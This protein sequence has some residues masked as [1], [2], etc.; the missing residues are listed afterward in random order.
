VTRSEGWDRT[1]IALVGGFLAADAGAILL[2]TALGK[3]VFDM[4]RHELDLG[5]LGLAGFVPAALLVLVSGSV[6]DRHER[7]TVAALAALGSAGASLVVALYV[8]GSPTAAGP[9]FFLA[10][11]VGVAHAFGAPSTRALPADIV[12]PERLPWLVARWSI[13]FQ[14]AHIVGP[15]LAGLLFVVDDSAPFVAAT[16][17]FLAATILYFRTP[18]GLGPR[19]KAPTGPG[20]H[21]AFEGLRLLRRTP[22]LLGAISLDLFAVLFG[23]AVA[24]LP[25]IADERLHVGPVAFG[26][27]RAAPGIGASA[28]MLMLAIRPLQRRI[29]PTLLG[30]VATF[31]VATIV[32]GITRSYVVAFVALVVLAGADAVSVFIRMTLV[33]LVTPNSARGRVMAVEN[34]FIGASNELGA[35]ESGVAGQLLGPGPAVALGGV[36][37][38]LIAAT[39][40]RVFPA[41]RRV[42]HFPA[43]QPDDPVA[44]GESG[45]GG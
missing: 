18:A 39:W 30:A 20:L 45:S 25:A 8:A 23:G 3:Q 44:A 21:D 32:L 17:L 37:T 13:A 29:G 34:V 9:L 14:L 28:V 43:R 42:D 11:A 36:A 38:L 15:V 1:S 26:W 41:L 6:A 24:L 2:A 4:T 5:L 12:P 27:L 33:P 31:G 40:G 16:A 35:F 22:I 19:A 10:F 7:R